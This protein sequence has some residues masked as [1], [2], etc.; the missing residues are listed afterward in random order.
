MRR[1]LADNDGIVLRPAVAL[2]RRASAGSGNAAIIATVRLCSL[3]SDAQNFTDLTLCR[4]DRY[5]KS[6]VIQV[7][8]A[9]VDAIPEECWL[10]A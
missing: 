1:R 3:V 2:K 4:P 8:P 5:C 6:L 7:T 10:T 9:E